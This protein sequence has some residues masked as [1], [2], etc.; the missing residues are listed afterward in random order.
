MP[1]ASAIRFGYACLSLPE[2]SA[3]NGLR[4]YLPVS[5]AAC[6]AAA[7]I[8][9]CL[10]ASYMYSHRDGEHCLLGANCYSIAGMAIAAGMAMSGIAIT[11]SA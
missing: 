5:L 11:D 4:Q 8:Y 1:E 7:C 6:Y 3:V 2:A 10:L 9:Q